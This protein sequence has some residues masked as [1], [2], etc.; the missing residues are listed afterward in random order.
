MKIVYEFTGCMHACMHACMQASKHP[1]IQASI[2][3][4]HPCIDA[5]MY[6]CTHCNN[7]RHSGFACT[8]KTEQIWWIDQI[9]QSERIRIRYLFDM[10]VEKRPNFNTDSTQNESALR[11]LGPMSY[12]YNFRWKIPEP[13]FSYFYVKLHQLYETLYHSQRIY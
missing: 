11:K 5:S 3:A 9:E 8:I 1:S 7:C 10:D 4:W 2:H 6:P 13:N 12:I